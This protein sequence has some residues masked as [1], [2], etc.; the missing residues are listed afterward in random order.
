MKIDKIM[1]D[2]EEQLKKDETRYKDSMYGEQDEFNRDLVGVSQVVETFHENT[3]LEKM[4]EI[5]SSVKRVELQ[6]R[7]M[8][9]K[10]KQ[11]NS[12]EVLFGVDQTEYTDLTNVVKAFEPYSKLWNPAA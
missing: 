12:R 5:H 4:E 7:Q 8:E 3:D 9:Q 1:L 2:V 10:A 11:F 6:L